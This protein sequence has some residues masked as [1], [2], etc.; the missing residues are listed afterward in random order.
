M[1]WQAIKTA[2]KGRAIVFDT[3]KGVFEAYLFGNDGRATYGHCN[4][5]AYNVTHWM[6]LPE[7]PQGE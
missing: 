1:E 3:E 5:Q 6:P 4:V 7:P 2:V